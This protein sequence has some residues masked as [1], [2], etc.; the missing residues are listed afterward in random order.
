MFEF[1]YLI[2]LIVFFIVGVYIT[3]WIFGI[4]RIIE[5]L[6]TQNRLAIKQIRLLAKMLII[7]GVE[8][9]EIDRIMEHGNPSK[10]GDG[11]E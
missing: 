5:G 2:L 11:G 9:E 10:K 1:T 8:K 3:R 6:E 7:Q 4:S